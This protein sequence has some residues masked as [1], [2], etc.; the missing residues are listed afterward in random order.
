MKILNISAQKPSSTGS[1]VFLTELVKEF[2]MQGHEQ[3]V[4]AGVYEEDTVSFPETV[5]FCPVYF[6]KDNLPY[7]IVGMS[8]EMPYPS[9]RYRDMTPEMVI[10][11]R[12][13]FLK[14]LRPLIEEFKPD[15]ILTHHL[16]LLT[17]IVRKYFPDQTVYGF[18]HNTDLRQMEK[19]DLERK[20]ISAYIRR[21]DRI[22]ALQEA[23]KKKI[24]QI[25]EV[26]P[27]KIHIIG[28]GYNSNIFFCKD[29]EKKDDVTRVVFAGKIAEK[30][31][32][33][34]LMRSLCLL[35]VP[36]D[37]LEVSLAGGA[38]NKE[39]YEEIV[40]LSK[41]CPYPV[42]FLGML[43]HN[44]LAEVYN[45]SDIFVLPSFFE[46][47][48]LTV[49]EAL[50][51]GNRVVMTDLPGISEWISENV[52]DP[53]IS[54]VSLPEMRNADE[55]VGET[56][57]DFEQRLAGALQKC[58]DKKETLKADTSRIS[59]EKIAEK[60]LNKTLEAGGK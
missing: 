32:L 4:V 15:V 28:M 13:A 3:V 22:F 40:R 21:L 10:Q 42:K 30:K 57:P 46:G 58:I 43:S 12:E 36:E 18:C 27:E 48:P 53:D 26:E 7:P 14:V 8:D 44:E 33:K 39:E 34:S 11:F 25:F 23:Q 50:A 2:H 16:Y 17:A 52:T 9:T 49:I 56:L 35:H 37:K 6:K 47:L 20:D 24:L 19:T 41:E 29:K 45:E 59:W 60:V 51:C 38:G 1:G 55:A 5:K 31:G 54:Y